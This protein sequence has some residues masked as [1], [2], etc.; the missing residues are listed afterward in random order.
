M[1]IV[2]SALGYFVFLVTTYLSGHR[3]C[4]IPWKTVGV[5]PVLQLLLAAILLQPAIRSLVL[6]LASDL[7]I[8]LKKTALIANESLLFS[9]VSAESFVRQHELMVA[10][11][12]AAILIFAASLSHVL[13]NTTGSCL[14][15][16]PGSAGSCRSLWASTQPRASA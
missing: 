5:A 4:S 6:G 15:S 12:I 11:E 3:T 10:F 7:T 9:I 1:S 16:S 8:L 13:Y 2:H 14:G